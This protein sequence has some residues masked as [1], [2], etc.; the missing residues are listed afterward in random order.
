MKKKLLYAGSFD[1]VTNGHLDMITRACALCDDMVIGVVK[2]HSKKSRYS[3]DDRVSMI[4]LAT[5]HLE[6]IE[7]DSFQGLL[8]DYVKDR[9]IN[10]VLRGLRA[11]AD[12]EYELQMAQMNAR[13]FEGKIETVFLMTNPEYSFVS[14]SIIHE[15]FSLG[16]DVSGLVP[17]RVLEYMKSLR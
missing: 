4:K 14:S 6:H 2:N 5:V 8:A 16:G 9:G 15:V 10:A 13:L 11:N 3:F 7:I 17:D 1:P 12:F